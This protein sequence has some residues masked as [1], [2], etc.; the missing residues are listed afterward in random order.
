MK[1][2]TKIRKKCENLTQYE[3][4]CSF[5]QLGKSVF[6]NVMQSLSKDGE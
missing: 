1:I 6:K 2:A 3:E 4:Y 5:M